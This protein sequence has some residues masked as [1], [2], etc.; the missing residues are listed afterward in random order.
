M[1]NFAALALA[2]SSILTPIESIQFVTNIIY[3]K[4][5]NKAAVS[6]RMLLGVV[7]ALVGTVLSVVFGAKGEGCF[8]LRQL[9]GFWTQGAWLV[10]FGVSVSVAIATWVWHAAQAKRA[11]T[12]A[13]LAE[14]TTITRPVLFTLSS[15]LA[16]GAQMIVHSKAFSVLLSM[17][18]QGE[19]ASLTSWLIYVSLVL[20][21]LCG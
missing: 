3:N 21:I 14:R 15:A 7:L 18:F 16:G 19:F 5:V 11:K 12:D 20:V 10:Y 13:A 9:E 2:P 4:L 8:T 6:R 17:L 1:I